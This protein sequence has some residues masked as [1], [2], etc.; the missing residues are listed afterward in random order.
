MD[1][2]SR[3]FL[4]IVAVAA[5]PF[6]VA[7]VYVLTSVFGSPTIGLRCTRSGAFAQCEVLQSRFLGLVGNDGFVIP[8]SE[9]DSVKTV[10]PVPHVGRGSGEYSVS[11]M[12]KTGAYRALPVL[13]SHSYARAEAARRKLNDYLANA[14]ATSIEV[15]EAPY[16]VLFILA[17]LSV[18]AAALVVF[19][20]RRTR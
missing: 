14:G 4:I 3:K 5:A 9:I 7:M 10:A 11:L 2:A 15:Q 19:A 1:S 16:E 6:F 12:L 17:P 18:L 8:E 20:R 13:H